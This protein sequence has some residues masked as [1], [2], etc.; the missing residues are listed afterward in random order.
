MRSHRSERLC[1]GV[2]LRTT[3][4]QRK[5]LETISEEHKIPLGESI[6]R[7]ID[8]AMTRAEV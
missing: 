8:E 7:L 3:A 5:F 1:D 4:T 2:A 6:R